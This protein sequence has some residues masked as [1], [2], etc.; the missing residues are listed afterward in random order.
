MRGRATL[1]LARGIGA[2]L[3]ALACGD[4][5]G[6]SGGDAPAGGGGV[7]DL[8]SG[9]ESVEAF[10][11]TLHPMLRQYCASCHEG[12]GPG[13]PHFAQSNVTA[14][15]QALVGQ[16]KVNLT[17][18]GASRLVVK[19]ASLAHHCWSEC[20]DDGAALAAAIAD[21]AARIDHAGGVGVDGALA[22]SAV[23][24]GDGVV[25]TGA[26]RYSRNLLALWEF[27]E[28][29]GSV[30]RDTSG[31]APAIDLALTGNVR[32]LSN[33]GVAFDQGMLLGSAA[34]SRKLYDAI[35]DPAAGTQQYSVEAWAT[36]ANIVQE[37]PARVVS[38]SRNSNSRNFTL[39]QVQYTYNV[40]NRS[41]HVDA[42]AGGQNGGPDL[43]TSDADRDAQD[44]LQHVV[45]TYDQFRGRRVYVDGVFTGDADPIGAARLWNWDPAHRVVM[46]DEVGGGRAWLGQLRL[47]AIYRQAL[48]DAQIRQ[49]FQA[50]VGERLLLRF[51]V[52]PWLGSGSAVEFI[53]SD[54]DG[55]SYL[56]CQP[57]LRT[58]NP[59][60]TRIANL[61][62]A[63]NGQLAA[64]GQGF[65]G[66]DTAAVDT[67][68]E[69]SRQCT[70][71]PKGS[72]PDGDRF[73]LV[74]EHL[75]GF[76]NVVVED[77]VDPASIPLDPE[78]RPRNGIRDFQR[79]NASF[80]SITAR[81]PGVASQVF[82]EIE[83]QLPSGYDARSFASSQQVAIA[84]L[85]LEY[86]DALV[87]GP[88]R[89]A[90]FPG[91][92]FSARADVAFASAAARDRIFVPLYDRAVGQ[93]LRM[94]PTR[95]EVR[96]ALDGLVDELTAGCA[97]GA[98]CSATRTRTIVKG[99]CA[100]VL[101]S[102]AVALH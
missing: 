75:G 7:I 23:A 37:G 18:P 15:H 34:A 72:G 58:P 5:S 90:F 100:A 30:A 46:G 102:A 69:L 98:D 66:I 76:L 42:Q 52:S 8:T 24:F 78:D 16:G 45:V 41:I 80:A 86:C 26:E 96:A 62:I 91:F 99:S 60:G 61:R 48:T 32:W 35:A 17:T 59:N 40:R 33:W 85:A 36:P 94:Q 70:V 54:F 97:S 49:N 47:V 93:D 25:D 29:N 74:F 21:W 87:E 3:L 81:D 55:Y 57:T 64:S 4:F 9:S 77:P 10:E 101:A 39:G 73:T 92:D 68:Q 14:S 1:G 28:G 27:K 2:A 65:V 11:A 95:A 44:R 19:V 13:S 79:L 50:G 89:G 53:V 51:D 56:F 31:V 88:G 6:G 22:S 71:I 82:A 84:K 83:E 43:Q 67:R 20:A 63:V 38:Y 12:N